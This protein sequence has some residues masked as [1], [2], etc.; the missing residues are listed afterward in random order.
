MVNL[1]PI[2]GLPQLD[3][4]NLDLLNE[5]L[6]SGS[7]ALTSNDDI[8]QLPTWLFGETPDELGALQNATA[9]VVI[10]VESKKHS[11]VTD[12]F[13]FYFYSYDQGPNIT[14][15]L[16]PL[17]GL[18]TDTEHGRHYGDHVGDW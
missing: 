10:L 12:A 9:C 8:R 4:D 1:E 6:N 15:V 3:L 14:Q 16:H 7:V 5:K 17:D 11:S 13:Y 18:L 2:A